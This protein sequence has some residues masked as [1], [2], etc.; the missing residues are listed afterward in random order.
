MVKGGTVLLYTPKNL[1]IILDLPYI[2]QNDKPYRC[3]AWRNKG[4]T[5]SLCDSRRTFRYRAGSTKRAHAATQ[6]LC[7]VHLFTHAIF[8]KAYDRDRLERAL[9]KRK[10]LQEA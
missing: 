3:M 5:S 6:D 7:W 1:R 4:T 9:K 2:T 8:L 10:K